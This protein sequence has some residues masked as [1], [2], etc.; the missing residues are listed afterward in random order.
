[1][2]HLLAV[3]IREADAVELD[4]AFDGVGGDRIGRVDG[5]RHEGEHR[6]H[7]LGAGERALQLAGGVG[8]RR[9]RSVHGPEIVDDDVQLADRQFAAHDEQAADDHDE[10]GPED[11]DR[12]DD[13]GEQG[14]LP[15]DGDPRLHRPFAGA[16]IALELV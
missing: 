3:G 15:G 2:Q 14:L 11:R 7:T 8:N 16:G 9:Q 5:F 13:D 4:L 6:A 1:M 10:R 12:A